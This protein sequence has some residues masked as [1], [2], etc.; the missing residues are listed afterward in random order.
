MLQLIGRYQV[1]ERIGRGAM[2]DVYRA[3]DPGIDRVIA[4]KVLKPEL[5]QNPEYVARFLREARAA[6]ALSHPSIVTIYDVGEVKG[7][8]YI[9]MEMLE[10]EPL[11]SVLKQQRRLSLDAVLAIGL[12]LGDALAY[13]HQ[14]GVVHRDIKPSNIVLAPDGRSVKILDFGIARLDETAGD[15]S[16]QTLRTQIGQVMG[17]PRYMSPEQVL[18]SEVDGR[19]DLFSTGV[20]L[21]ELIT[22]QRAFTGANSGTLAL[23][24]IREDPRPI[25]ELVEDIPAGLQFIIGKLLAKRPDRRFPDGA[26][27]AAAFRREADAL[28][29][30][31]AETKARRY[32]PMP[33]RMALTMAGV[34]ALVLALSTWGVMDR[35]YKAMERMALSSG[36]AIATFIASNASLSAVENA[37]LPVGEQDWAPVT[38]FVH[39]SSTDPNV[40]QMM[41]VDADGV[42]QAA[43][44]ARLVG[45]RYKTPADEVVVHRAG[46]VS[47]TEALGPNGEP[48]FRFVR[49]IQYAGHNFG[50]VDVSLSKA[51]LVGAAKLSTMLMGALALIVTLVVGLVSY[52]G[53]KLLARPIRRL[54]DALAEAA[55]AGG[56]LR[57]SHDR[58]DEFGELFDSFNH[59]SAVVQDRI[60]QAEIQTGPSRAEAG[61]PAPAHGALSGATPAAFLADAT[62]IS[63]AVDCAL[64]RTQIAPAPT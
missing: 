40:Q 11:D 63:A 52:A 12:Q 1:Q 55:E 16:D 48:G 2:A 4:I 20:V 23:Q 61:V 38:A 19:S 7:Y 27:L 39:A 43:S 42:I 10:G 56:G 13:A 29:A 35:Q 58:R 26:A 41:V 3:H 60:D 36:S 37:G 45:R 5:R 44:D 22:G 33:V 9:A 6:G 46:G 50:L 18:G 62:M 14:A 24:I 54:R 53:T 17:T 34:T 32:I 25:G 21:Y 15:E 64:E 30:A 31:S 57:I 28:A 51:E 47:T 8:P 59:L 49:P